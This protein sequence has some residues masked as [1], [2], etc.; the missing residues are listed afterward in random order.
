[1]S[2]NRGDIIHYTFICSCLHREFK[3][4]KTIEK[5]NAG[6]LLWIVNLLFLIVILKDSPNSERST[7]S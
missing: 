7:E 2:G 3:L 5:Y 4:D 1:M 6:L